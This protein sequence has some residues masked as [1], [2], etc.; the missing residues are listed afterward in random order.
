MPFRVFR[1]HHNIGGKNNLNSSIYLKSS[2]AAEMVVVT[3]INILMR[4]LQIIRGLLDMLV[5][6][7][8]GPPNNNNI[9]QSSKPHMQFIL[10][11]RHNRPTSIMLL[12]FVIVPLDRALNPSHA[13]QTS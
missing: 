7:V 4:W 13:C 11:D 10:I 6:T 8:E 2:I 12:F 9:Q 5:G 3:T 1:I